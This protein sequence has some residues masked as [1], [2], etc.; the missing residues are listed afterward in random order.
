MNK[1]A[2]IRSIQQDEV[3]KLLELYKYLHEE[4][5]ELNLLEIQSLWEQI[6]NDKNLHYLVVDVEGRL[7]AS[8]VLI[9]IPNLTRNARPY[10]IIENVVAHPDFQ[11]KGYGTKLLRKSLDIAWEHNC[12]KVMLLTGSKEEGTLKFYENA[13]FQ[14]GV[15]TGFIATP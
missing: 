15:K 2:V 7:V 11:R 4:D 12:Y 9:L 13:G 1:N 6:Y 5:P 14:M 8:C 3:H 10:G